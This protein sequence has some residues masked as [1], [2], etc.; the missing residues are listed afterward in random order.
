MTNEFTIDKTE[1]VQPTKCLQTRKKKILSFNHTYQKK[2]KKP[3][4]SIISIFCSRST[5]TFLEWQT[6][7][8]ARKRCKIVSCK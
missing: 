7:L 3:T 5:V 6:L 1:Y 8:D 4:V 2:K